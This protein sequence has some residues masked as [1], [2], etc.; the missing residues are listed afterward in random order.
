MKIRHNFFEEQV[1]QET[2]RYFKNV[3]SY[4]S[5]N[6]LNMVKLRRSFNNK[7]K[8]FHDVDSPYLTYKNNQRNTEIVLDAPE[9]RLYIR[10]ECKTQVEYSNMI[11]RLYD[12]LDYV[13]DLPE[14]MICFVLEGALLCPEVITKFA[15]KIKAMKLQNRVWFG[16]IDDFN[17]FLSERIS[18]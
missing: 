12:E 14:D 5:G 4:E 9:H 6:T 16:S 11:T 17:K 13:N 18:A 7:T 15:L 10:I 3:Q 2:K 8:F 1:K